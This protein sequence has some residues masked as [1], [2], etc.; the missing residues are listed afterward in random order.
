MI[1]ADDFRL[2]EERFRLD[3][4][5][6]TKQW[7]KA[8]EAAERM[9]QRLDMENCYNRQY[10]GEIYYIIE[11]VRSGIPSGERMERLLSLLKL[12]IP[13]FVLTEH[14]R[15]WPEVFW[16]TVFTSE[17][18]SI[19]SQIA[20]AL[21]CDG[22][23]EDSIYLAEKLYGYYKKSAVRP[24]FHFR[25]LLGILAQLS[26][27]LGTPGRYE[28]CIRYSQEGIALCFVSRKMSEMGLFVNNIANAKECL[29]DKAFAL[30]YY[31]YAFY[32]EELLGN[33]SEIPR[34]SYEKLN[35]KEAEWY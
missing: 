11:L 19:L 6:E 30:R 34:R 13:D 17:E 14:V 24:E 2:L 15:E 12:T 27:L 25:T 5:I 7:Q 18:I 32:C 4:M 9:E 22:K 33:S 21:R 20:R 26:I 35:G 8:K 3:W 31:R 29:G 10:L 23:T 28:E 1:E 16:C